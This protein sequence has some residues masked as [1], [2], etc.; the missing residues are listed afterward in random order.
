MPLASPTFSPP[1]T[2]AEWWAVFLKLAADN[3]I[4][5]GLVLLFIAVFVF[6]LYADRAGIR[7]D[8]AAWLSWPTLHEYFEEHPEAQ[9]KRGVVCYHCRSANIRNFAFG[10]LVMRAVACRACDNTLYRIENCGR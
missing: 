8:Y 1:T 3:P 5:V 4:V 9:T 2:F 6:A 10:S 7:R